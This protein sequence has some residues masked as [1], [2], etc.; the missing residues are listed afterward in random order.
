MSGKVL[1]KLMGLLDAC[2]D[3]RLS[4][5]GC[6]RAAYTRQLNWGCIPKGRRGKRRSGGRHAPKGTCDRP[7]STACRSSYQRKPRERACRLSR[8]LGG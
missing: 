1:L 7:A 4:L 3:M 2:P 6:A 5:Q 8:A